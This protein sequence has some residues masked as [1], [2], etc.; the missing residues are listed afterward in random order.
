MYNNIAIENFINFCDDMMIVEEGMDYKTM[1]KLQTNT[2][3]LNN[4]LLMQKSICKKEY[5]KAKNEGSKDIFISSLEKKKEGIQ[6]KING[7]EVKNKKV[8]QKFIAL[9]DEYIRKAESLPE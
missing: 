9:Y 7:T 8:L 3:A 4:Q 1:R 6:R 5:K 2:I